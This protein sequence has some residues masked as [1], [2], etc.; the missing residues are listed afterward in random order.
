MSIM[1]QGLDVIILDDDPLIS[2]LLKQMVSN[3]YQWGEIQTFT[4]VMLAKRFCYDRESS[5]AVFI[6]DV[7]L[8]ELT[9]FDFIDA[10]RVHYPMV[11]EDSII[12]TG[13]ASEDVVDM[14]LASDVYYLLEK[15]VKFYALQFAIRAIA[16]K[17]LRFARHL[18]HDP[19]FARQVEQIEPPA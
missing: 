11:Y 6:L 1:S 8:G 10:I 19:D 12:I 17:Y 14:C 9:A 15:P 16:N 18:R 3:F 2:E 13:D 7:F 5:V 4:D